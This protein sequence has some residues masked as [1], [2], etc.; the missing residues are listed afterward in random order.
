MFR[1]SF[2]AAD[3]FDDETALLSRFTPESVEQSVE[4]FRTFLMGIGYHPEVI[5]QLVP[6]PRRMW[7][8]VEG[9]EESQQE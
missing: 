6:D 9:G 2:R 1:I 4:R 7:R 5:E 3:P 8:Y